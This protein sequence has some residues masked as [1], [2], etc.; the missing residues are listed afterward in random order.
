M[1]QS[2]INGPIQ[3]D[4]NTP[5]DPQSIQAEMQAAMD[6]LKTRRAAV[7]SNAIGIQNTFKS[8]KPQAVKGFFDL[9]KSFGVNPADQASVQAFLEWAKDASPDLYTMIVNQFEQIFGQNSPF[10]KGPADAAAG[11]SPFQAYSLQAPQ[12]SPT[13]GPF[14]MPQM[15]G[16]SSLGASPASPPAI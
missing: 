3:P 13:S 4:P 15:P 8:A 10:D 16:L 11:S 1:Q 5:N 6:A 12:T 7:D 9:L 14:Q 2:A